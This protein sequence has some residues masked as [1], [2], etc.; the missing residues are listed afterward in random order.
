[1]T[2]R[3]ILSVASFIPLDPKGTPYDPV[4]G[5]RI[6]AFCPNPKCGLR[7]SISRR[8]DDLAERI[9]AWPPPDAVLLRPS[10]LHG[11]TVP[12]VAEHDPADSGCIV[13]PELATAPGK[14]PSV[15]RCYACGR[16][17]N[18][19]TIEGDLKSARLGW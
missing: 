5:V 1:L 6:V 13:H 19:A 9:A 15:L 10:H 8:A 3:G 18:I 2:L 12:L 17:L 16:R 11:Y 14:V 7:G 4:P